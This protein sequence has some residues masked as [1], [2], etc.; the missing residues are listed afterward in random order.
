[1]TGRQDIVVSDDQIQVVVNRQNSQRPQQLYRNLQRLGIR[2]VHFIPLL[3]HDRNGMLTEDSLCSADWGRFLNSVFD[4]WVREDI[5]RIS[6]RLFDETLQQWCGGGCPEHRDSQGKNR[7]CEGYQTF[8]NYSSPHMR[9]MRD[10]LKQH[11]SPE[12]LMAMLR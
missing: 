5:Q 4:I 2:N 1:M 6:V 9:V 11:R 10:L 7:L 8:F 12:E 3:E